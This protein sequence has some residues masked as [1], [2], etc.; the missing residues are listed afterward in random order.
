M[1]F[2]ICTNSIDIYQC[3]IIAEVENLADAITMAKA[4]SEKIVPEV[5]IMSS[6]TGEI[7][8][9]YEDGQIVFVSD[10]LDYTG[11]R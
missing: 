6:T 2:S 3:R 9:T 1:R 7:I 4:L 10:F 5:D 11:D 8:L